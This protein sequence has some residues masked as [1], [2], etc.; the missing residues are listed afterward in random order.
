MPDTETTTPLILTERRD[1]VAASK[2][3]FKGV[4]SSLIVQIVR[5]GDGLAPRYG[6]TASKK[7]GNAVVRNRAK[8]RLRAIVRALLAEQ[9]E[10]G[11]DYVLIARHNTVSVDWAQLT[12][13]FTKALGR[14][15]S[16][17]ARQAV[18]NQQSS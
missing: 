16:Q 12:A 7:I 18:P 3:G 4:A 5:R 9:A 11:A 17:T 15:A 8:R 2:R 14:A 6:I 1:F 13:D 10:L